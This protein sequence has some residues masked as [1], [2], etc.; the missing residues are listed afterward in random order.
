LLIPKKNQIR[1]QAATQIRYYSDGLLVERCGLSLELFNDPENELPLVSAAQ[2][3]DF[4][5]RAC[6]LS[7]FGLLVGMR[8][9]LSSLGLIGHL[10]QSAPTVA[11]A[12]SNLM[13]HMPAHDRGA[14]AHLTIEGDKATLAYF[15][16]HP[17][18]PGADHFNDGATATLAKIMRR[19]C[20]EDWRPSRVHLTRRRPANTAPYAEFFTTEI[21]FGAEAAGLSFPVHT[22]QNPL[23]GANKSL[24]DCLTKLVIRV[25]TRFGSCAQEARRLI[26]LQLFGGRPSA[27]RAAASIGIHRRTLARRGGNVR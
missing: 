7:H 5:S 14:Q 13:R 3:L 15:I 11:E 16:D 1:A 26:R 25:E 18:S 4:C 9:D 10:A 22:L 19:L 23:P 8:N 2:L 20:G 21:A 27:D 12:L 24:H 6:G 17:N